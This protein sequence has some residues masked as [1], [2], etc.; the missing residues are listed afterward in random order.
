[1]NRT[2]FLWEKLVSFDNI[3]KAYDNTVRGKGYRQCVLLFNKDLEQSLLSLQKKLM[4]K[5]YKP[6]EYATFTIYEPKRRMIS[7]APFIDRIVHHCLV[8]VIGPVF[9]AAFV[10]QSYA[11]RIGKGTH[12]AVRDVQNAMRLNRYIMHCD[13]VKYFASVDHDILK[14]LIRRKIKDPDVIWLVDTIIDC[15]NPQETVTDYFNGDSLSTP[16]ERRKGLPIGNLTSQFFANVYLNGLDHFVKEKLGCPFYARYVDDIVVLDSSKSKLWDICGEI[17]QYIE[18]LRL[19]LHPNK[20]HV[21]PVYRG[22]TFLGQVIFPERRLLPKRNIK[23]FMRRMK[24]FQNRLEEG[25][26]PIDAIRHSFQSWL[27]H[28]KQANTHRLRESLYEKY[29][30][31]R[32]LDSVEVTL[33]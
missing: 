25:A 30:F 24:H 9:E 11:N 14:S 7:A 6:G 22:I 29:P 12:R 32:S 13:I 21:R 2:G 17:N 19:R 28:A 20:Q 33:S 16:L 8:N 3:L 27:G 18:K 1:M 5:N 26:M 4:T 10:S 23:R 15:G 31:L